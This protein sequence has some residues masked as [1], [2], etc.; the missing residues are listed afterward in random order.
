LDHTALVLCSKIHKAFGFDPGPK[1][2][3]EALIQLC[4]ENEFDPVG[5]YL[6]GLKWD[7]TPRLDRWTITYLGAADTELNREFGRLALLAAVRRV[8]HPGSKFD[9]IVVLEG[10]MGTKKSMAIEIMAGSENFSDQTILGARDR[11]VQELLAGIWLFEIAELSNIRRTE[12]EH[13]KAFASRT[14]DR[15]RPAYGRVREDR[16]RGACCSRRR[17]TLST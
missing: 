10:P 16:P 5:D 8:R 3:V 9:P 17:T 13:I 6:N 14:V 12:V 7:G 4:L 15:A 2:T 11:E 1:N